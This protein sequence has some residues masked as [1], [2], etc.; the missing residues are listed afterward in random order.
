VKNYRLS[1]A[2][3]KQIEKEASEWQETTA[4]MARFLSLGKEHA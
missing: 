4:L 1:R 2:G 3:R